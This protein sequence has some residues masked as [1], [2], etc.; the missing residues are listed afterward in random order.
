MSHAASQSQSAKTHT[1]LRH[2]RIKLTDVI[3]VTLYNLSNRL[4]SSLIIKKWVNMRVAKFGR[5]AVIVTLNHTQ[6]PRVF[7][8][9]MRVSDFGNF[10]FSTKKRKKNLCLV[11]CGPPCC[12]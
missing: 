10:G 9:H 7:I 3:I 5:D 6:G 11:A 2:L 8:H 12:V 4:D 1:Q